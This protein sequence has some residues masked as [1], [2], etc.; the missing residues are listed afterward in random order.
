MRDIITLQ[1]GQCKNRNY[2]TLKNKSNTPGRLERSKYCP[3][4]RAHTGHK[5]IK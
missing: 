5:E 3:H 1:C 2:S 4:C